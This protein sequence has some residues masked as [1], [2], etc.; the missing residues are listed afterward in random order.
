L[1]L[2]PASAFLLA[3]WIVD[4]VIP[5]FGYRHRLIV[6]RAAIATCLLLAAANFLFIPAYELHGCGAPF[7]I[8]NMLRWPSAGFAG[9]SS[10]RSGQPESYREATAQINRLVGS[11]AAL[12][13]FGFQDALEPLIF[14]LGR[15]AP[16]LRTPV[17]V[18]PNARIIAP[19][20]VWARLR[21]R[22]P[23]LTPIARIPYDGDPLILLG[24]NALAITRGCTTG[25]RG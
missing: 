3:W 22:Y 12:Y 25:S 14:Y 23:S 18:P 13:T 8:S 24:N 17:S 9:E 2:W 4:R 21:M 19:A 6:Y 20:K 5:F 16:L 11:D 15:C 7:T 10:E 1:P